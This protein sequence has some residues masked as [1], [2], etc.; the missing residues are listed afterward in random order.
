MEITLEQQ[1]ELKAMIASVYYLEGEA[2][3]T[4]LSPVACIFR[5]ALADIEKWLKNDVFNPE[6]Y[7]SHLVDP[8][9]YKI[10]ELFSKFR[11]TPKC[12]LQA[13]MNSIDGYDEIRNKSN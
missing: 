2:D 10:F 13:I 3:K 12:D 5:N 6:N 8:E 7:L 9:L 1:E 11:G 4:G